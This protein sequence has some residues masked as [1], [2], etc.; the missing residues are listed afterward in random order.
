MIDEIKSKWDYLND[1]KG[2]MQRIDPNHPMDF[3]ASVSTLGQVQLIL[4]TESEPSK[5]KSSYGLKVDKNKRRDGRWATQIS[6]EDPKNVDVF[7]RLCEDLMDV[8]MPFNVE[9]QGLNAVTNRFVVWQRMFESIHTSLGTNT[10]KGLI[11]E[12]EFASKYLSR[13]RKW[14]DILDGWRG[15]DAGDRDYV[16]DDCWYE[17]KA[18]ATGK[19]TVS[20]SSLDQLD[21]DECGELI[22]FRIDT[23]SSQD[24]QSFNVRDYIK[25]IKQGLSHDLNLLRKF[26]IKMIET[27]Y[28]DK[29]DYGEIWFTCSSPTRYKVDD[30]FPRLTSN[31]VPSEIVKANYELSLAAIN[32]W[33]IEDNS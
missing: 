28:V 20:I 2:L 24:P 12:L 29:E 11:G 15:P 33:K 22:V 26:E 5:L 8:S 7:S 31:N 14:D 30:V 4:L 3:F 17:I 23:T 16:F 9:V 13:S 19:T 32:N 18:V 10:L 6:N 21:T 27:G 1:H 25:S